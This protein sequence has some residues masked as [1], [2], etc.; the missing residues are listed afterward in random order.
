MA[1][2]GEWV[3]PIPCGAAR[4]HPALGHPLERVW[5]S[6]Q[7]LGG[8]VLLLSQPGWPQVPSSPQVLFRLWHNVPTNLTVRRRKELKLQPPALMLPSAPARPFSR[9]CRQY[10]MPSPTMIWEG[11]AGSGGTGRVWD[12]GRATRQML[13][14]ARHWDPNP[15]LCPDPH[16]GTSPDAPRRRARRRPG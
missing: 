3:T 2:V 9:D 5:C 6:V 8:A 12:V 4:T 13:D 14:T 7:G 15:R 10:T 1:G 11:T 16:S